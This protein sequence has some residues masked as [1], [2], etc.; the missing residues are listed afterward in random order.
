MART[1][2]TKRPDSSRDVSNVKVYVDDSG[3]LRPN[4]RAVFRARMKAM[5]VD[6]ND[7]TK[8]KP[9]PPEKAKAAAG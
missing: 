6:A 9:V 5:G 8:A 2:T 1:R 7:T 3:V 4:M